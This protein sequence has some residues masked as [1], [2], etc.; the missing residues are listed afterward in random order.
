MRDAVSTAAEET[1]N[2]QR[3]M[4]IGLIGA[5][6]GEQVDPKA[7]ANFH[8]LVR[9]GRAAGMRTI[10]KLVFY[11]VHPFGD[12]QWDMLWNNTDGTQEKVIEGWTRIWTRYKD[13]PSVFGYD[14]LN[15]PTRGFDDDYEGIQSEKMLPLLRRMT[16]SVQAISP[17]K[18]VLYQPLLRKPEDQKIKPRDPAVGNDEPF[19]RERVIYAPHLYQMNTDVIAPMLEAFERQAM[20][21]KAP[22]LLG[23]WGSPIYS[24]TDGNPGQ[25]ALYSRVYQETVNEMDRRCIGGIKAWF[26]G[27]RKPIPVKGP[28]KWMT[29]SIFSDRSPAGRIERKYLM[30]VV[31]RPRP[32]VV[33]GR[34]ERY[35]NDFSESCFEM[36]LR[37][38]P[39]LGATEIFVPAERHYPHGFRVEVGSGLT[40]LHE[41]GASELRGIHA[42]TAG[43][44]EQAKRIRWDDAKQRLIVEEWIGTTR[45]ISIRVMPIGEN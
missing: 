15:E 33:A 10:F 24:D 11:G 25:E 32:L 9:L 36:E 7:M 30:D 22:I 13:E 34:L 1:R 6:P 40:L 14:L 42:A 16:D 44:R 29:W 27:A 2:P 43:D 39:A 5:W 8:E 38:N 23:E 12:Q 26:C 17:E 45:K 20:I 41:G 19:G 28:R 4:P 21:S 37:T 35:G 3:N 31:V 18:W